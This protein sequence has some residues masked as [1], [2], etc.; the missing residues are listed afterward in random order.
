[1]PSLILAAGGVQLAS[2]LRSLLEGWEQ[3]QIHVL[4]QAIPVDVIAL[5][6]L[7]PL[8]QAARAVDSLSSTLF[9]LVVALGTV[10][11][12]LLFLLVG[13]VAGWIYNLVARLSGG[14]EVELT[15]ARRS[16]GTRRDS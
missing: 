11:G 6:N 9:I 4:G 2:G 16:R 15:E 12:G 13:D 5:L 10:L 8:L 14:L 7:E 3:A 1:V